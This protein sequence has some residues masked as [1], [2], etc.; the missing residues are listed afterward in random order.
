MPTNNEMS[1]GWGIAFKLD[2]DQNP[3]LYTTDSKD[4]IFV[5]DPMN[6]N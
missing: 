6:W 3:R 2:K 1:E 5:I 4:K